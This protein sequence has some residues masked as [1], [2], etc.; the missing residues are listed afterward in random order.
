MIIELL[1]VR[2]GGITSEPPVADVTAVP[3]D[4]VAFREPC[5]DEP[6]IVSFDEGLGAPV[7]VDRSMFDVGDVGISPWPPVELAV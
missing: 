2:V 6:A 5:V 3:P 4:T 1:A 7:P